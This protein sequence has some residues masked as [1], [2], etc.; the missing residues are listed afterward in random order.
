MFVNDRVFFSEFLTKKT[1]A[2]AMRL[3]HIAPNLVVCGF[4]LRQLHPR[5]FYII[6][7]STRS[8]F[9]HT[10]RTKKKKKKKRLVSFT[11]TADQVWEEIISNDRLAQVGTIL[12]SF[13]LAVAVV[14]TDTQPS[15]DSCIFTP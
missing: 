2:I 13:Q 11:E 15:P 14:L 6:G 10:L 7:S 8:K 3:Q 9:T 1:S 5:S 12:D 4:F